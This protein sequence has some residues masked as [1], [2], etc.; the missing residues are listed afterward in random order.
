M[1]LFEQYFNQYILYI[2]Y[3]AA[4][5][6][7]QPPDVT[8]NINIA[9]MGNHRHSQSQHAHAQSVRVTGGAITGMDFG[10]GGIYLIMCLIKNNTKNSP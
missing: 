10:D 7:S 1:L 9:P 6:A 8:S 4:Q 2:I 5:H 3:F